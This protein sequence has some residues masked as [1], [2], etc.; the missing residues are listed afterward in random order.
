MRTLSYFQICFLKAGEVERNKINTQ[1]SKF[2]M[3]KSLSCQGHT[4]L[5]GII[6]KNIHKFEK[7]YQILLI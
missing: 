4:L 7:I 6:V 2:D 5:Y 1:N 3:T